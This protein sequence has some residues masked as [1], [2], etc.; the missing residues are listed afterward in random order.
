MN[1]RYR[2]GPRSGQVWTGRDS[3]T[4]MVGCISDIK[5]GEPIGLYRRQGNELVWYVP[6]PARIKVRDT[7]PF[8]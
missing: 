3:R 5:L 2:G 6:T 1:L 8:A 4:L 7:R